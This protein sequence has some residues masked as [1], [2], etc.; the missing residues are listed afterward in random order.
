MLFFPPPLAPFYVVC[1]FLCHFS[2]STVFHPTV[3]FISA[4]SHNR[5]GDGVTPNEFGWKA[6]ARLKPGPLNYLNQAWRMG[7]HWE[8]SYIPPRT[9]WSAL[10][11][12]SSGR[13]QLLQ[14]P[15][16]QHSNKAPVLFPTAYRQ[17]F[18]SSNL[19]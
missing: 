2:F 7:S 9:T 15:K 10:A 4:L 5:V 6:E 3:Y 8:K 11:L 1:V 18:A 12:Y 17:P 19:N 16:K 13:P 14:A